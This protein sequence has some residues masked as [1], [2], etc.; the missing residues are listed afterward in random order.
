MPSSFNQAFPAAPTFTE[1]NV[2]DLEGRVGN[3]SG[4]QGRRPLTCFPDL[5][6]YRR[7]FRR[8]VR[9]RQAALQPKRQHLHRCRSAEKVGRA[10]KTI[11]ASAPS[12]K[13]RLASLI[14]ELANFPTIKKA[15]NKFLA[16]ED[17]VDI[18]VYKAGLMTP[19]AGSQDKLV[20]SL[21][22]CSLLSKR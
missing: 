8:R 19:P 3:G 12:S 1:K 10:I 14:L 21:I 2:G 18:L 22:L 17:R 9:A 11:K 15:V 6:H 4:V 13:G 5:H 20:S 16:R 7:R